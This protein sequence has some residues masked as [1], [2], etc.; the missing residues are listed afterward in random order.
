MGKNESRFHCCA[1]CRHFAINKTGERI[2]PYC[3]RLGYE[4]K[5][6]Y[7]FNCWDPKERVKQAMKKERGSGPHKENHA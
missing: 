1:T 2:I 3:A 5:P 4:T 7:Q 6:D